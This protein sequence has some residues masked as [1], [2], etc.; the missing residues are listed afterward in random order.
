[1]VAVEWPG[2]YN[3]APIPDMPAGSI[4]LGSVWRGLPRLCHVTLH[5]RL[6]SY[7]TAK[8]GIV[9]LNGQSAPFLATQNYTNLTDRDRFRN[10]SD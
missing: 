3:I 4:A 5:Y 8:H 7:L 1:M 10:D 6:Q 9:R 2:E